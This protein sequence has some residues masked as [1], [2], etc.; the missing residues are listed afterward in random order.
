MNFLKTFN[1]DFSY[2]E[3]WLTNQNSKRSSMM[4]FS[5]TITKKKWLRRH[6]TVMRLFYVWQ[7]V[8]KAKFI[9]R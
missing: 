9:L 1:L 6:F 4:S 8:L 5:T 3:V 7:I 2:I